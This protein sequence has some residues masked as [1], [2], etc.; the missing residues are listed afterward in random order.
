MLCSQ[1]LHALFLSR[2]VFGLGE[3]IENL[4]NRV[5]A[6]AFEKAVLR[7]LEAIDT[8]DSGVAVDSDLISMLRSLSCNPSLMFINGIVS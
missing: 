3:N 2:V 1:L 5:A 4:F 6:L 8:T 7:E